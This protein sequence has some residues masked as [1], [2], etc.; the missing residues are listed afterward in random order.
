MVAWLVLVWV[1]KQRFF[2]SCLVF[3]F[4]KQFVIVSIN[5]ACE[6]SGLGSH[7]PQNFTIIKSG[8]MENKKAGGL[9]HQKKELIKLVLLLLF[10]FVLILLFALNYEAIK[11]FI[12]NRM[13]GYP[14]PVFWQ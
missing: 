8:G 1:I 12:S 3:I 13:A 9:L 10:F 6:I 5:I 4:S 7:Q 2:F 14:L 11:L